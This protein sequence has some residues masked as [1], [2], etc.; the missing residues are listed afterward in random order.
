MS[1]SG[2]HVIKGNDKPC[3]NYA[4]KNKTCCWVHRKFEE[5]P[6]TEKDG[7]IKKTVVVSDSDQCVV[8]CKTGRR[9]S[10]LWSSYDPNMC[11]QHKNL[12]EFQKRLNPAPIGESEFFTSGKFHK[13]QLA[14]KDR[15]SGSES[16]SESESESDSDDYRKDPSYRCSSRS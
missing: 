14:S 6:Y 4:L 16:E 12:S 10:R 2:C 3:G 15:T 9:C 11:R 8:I 1:G 7:E 5:S 13:I